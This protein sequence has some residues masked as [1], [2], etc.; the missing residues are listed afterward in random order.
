MTGGRWAGAVR[1]FWLALTTP[2]WL[3]AD[4]IQR[5]MAEDATGRASERPPEAMVRAAR[6]T[7]A[8]LARIPFSP[9]RNTC[10]YR[11][12]AVCRCL[13]DAGIPA[14]LRI[15]VSGEE[16]RAGAGDRVAAHAWV[17]STGAVAAG[18][19]EPEPDEAFAPLR[20]RAGNRP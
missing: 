17:E 6:A 14:R 16:G 8:R 2:T 9:W 19:L 20:P 13:R 7:L 3:R 10:L 4:R 1:G 15:G 18:L 5:L 11:S 12:I